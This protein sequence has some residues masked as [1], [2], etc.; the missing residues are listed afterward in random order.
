M[1]LSLLVE[2]SAPPLPGSTCPTEPVTAAMSTARI[3]QPATPSAT[4][5]STVTK[6][7]ATEEK[8]SFPQLPTGTMTAHERDVLEGRLSFENDA[9]QTDFAHL[10][11]GTCKSLN[12]RIN[13]REAVF[14]L[15]QCH[16]VQQREEAPKEYKND[17]RNAQSM[18][19]AFDAITPFFSFFGYSLIAAIIANFGTDEDKQRLTEYEQRFNAFCKRRV[20]ECPIEAFGSKGTDDTLLVVKLNDEFE[21]FTLK[22]VAQFRTKLSTILGVPDYALRFIGAAEGCVELQ[23]A[24]VSSWGWVIFP[25]SGQQRESLRGEGVLE[26]R[27]GEHCY[28]LSSTGDKILDVKGWL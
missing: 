21:N 15:S 2:V 16:C 18:Y 24:A 12:D 1:H 5:F 3:S 28:L 7:A 6:P 14:F 10:V 26:L 13:L 27:G 20:Y 25:L 8:P 23:F 9:I 22:A 11:F 4:C 19:D 17:L